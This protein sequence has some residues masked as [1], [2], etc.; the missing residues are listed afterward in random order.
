MKRWFEKKKRNSLEPKRTHPTLYPNLLTDP[1][2][3]ALS[4]FVCGNGEGLNK[5]LQKNV[6]IHVAIELSRLP[7]IRPRTRKANIYVIL[8]LRFKKTH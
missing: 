2:G 6:M 4:Q 8:V 7:L 3:Q 1:L 5:V